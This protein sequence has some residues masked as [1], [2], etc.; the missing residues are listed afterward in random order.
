MTLEEEIAIVRFGQG[1]LSLADLLSHFNQLEEGKKKN[2]LFQLSSLVDFADPVDAD[3]ELAIA[4]CP[5]EATDPLCVALAIDRFRVNRIGMLKEEDFDRA[6]TL[7]A[8]LFKT[9]YQ[10]SY[11]T[12]KD[13]PTQWWFW[14][15]SENEIGSTIRTAHQKLVD[16]VYHNPSFRGEFASLAKL[17]IAQEELIKTRYQEHAP[18]PERASDFVSYEEIV[19]EWVKMQKEDVKYSHGIAALRNS[20]DRALSAKYGLNPAQAWRLIK[21]V[22]EQHS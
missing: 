1:V 11:K 7:Q 2:L 18:V 6:Y 21:D 9:A 15:L 8:Y 5:L 14:D 17:W 22:M 4:D 12:K 10:R 20:L 13:S 19:S 3:I 16:E